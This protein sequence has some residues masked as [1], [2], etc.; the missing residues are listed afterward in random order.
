MKEI[1]QN[2]KNIQEDISEMKVDLRS[3]IRRTD[4]LEKEV[5]PMRK[6]YDASWL[7]LRI[8]AVCGTVFGIFKY[9]N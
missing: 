9:L 7:L 3:H 8:A 1:K 4:I 6:L 5:K 2:L